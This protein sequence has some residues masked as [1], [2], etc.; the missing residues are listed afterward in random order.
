[1]TPTLQDGSNFAIDQNIALEG[2]YQLTPR[3][4]A[5][6]GGRWGQRSFKGQLGPTPNFVTDDRQEAYYGSI[7]M[8]VG[9][10]AS[11]A[12]D[13]RRDTRNTNLTLFNYNAYRVGV[14]ATQTF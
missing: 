11:L 6:L 9:R 8:T 14:T 7:Q 5:S 1:M 13:V 4:K 10:H 12:L 3:L 2:H